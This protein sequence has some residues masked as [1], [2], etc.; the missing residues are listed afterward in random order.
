METKLIK[1]AC[2]CRVSTKSEEQEQ[3]FEAQQA[4]FKEKLS[5]KNGYDLVEIYA[6]RGLSGTDF[7]KREQFNKMLEDCG[8]IKKEVKARETE[9]RKK[10]ISIDYVADAGITPRFN[11][12]YVKDSSRF[13]RNTEVSRIITRLR[14]KGVFVYFEDLNK[15][16]ENPNEK[17]LIDFMF[18]MSEQESIS[19]STKVRFGNVQSAKEGIVRSMRLYGYQYNKEENSLRIIPEE[20]ETVKLIFDLRLEGYGGRAIVTELN[21]RG[22]KNRKGNGWRANTINSMLQNLVYCGKVVRNKW[23]S[24][25]MYGKDIVTLNKRDKWI[26]EDSEKVD[27][28]INEETFEKVQEMIE[29]N[30]QKVGRVQGQYHGRSEFAEKIKCEK[31]GKYYVRNVDRGRIFYNCSTKKQHGTK[32][33]NGRNIQEREIEELIKPYLVLGEY[34]NIT[35]KYIGM[36]IEREE[37]KKA[38]LYMS[39]NI[40]EVN[41]INAEIAEYKKKLAKLTEAFLDDDSEGVNDIFSSKK[42]EL[43]EKIKALEINRNKLSTTDEEK[44]EMF[45]R[46]DIFINYLKEQY[47]KC[48]EEVTRE[49]FINKYLYKIRVSEDGKLNLITY[50]QYGYEK[51]IE[52]MN[53]NII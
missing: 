24:S 17:M 13:A 15:S 20:A 29:G 39:T 9:I 50:A 34:K 25:R 23:Y 32:N 19:R 38:T 12:I 14:D 10:Y 18:S 21:Q 37:E 43:S 46:M 35:K 7:S 11:L 31:C 1:V 3:S 22:I 6:D 49:E 53:K 8:I 2:Y 45:Q 4:Y 41:Q 36:M 5:K 40:E 26:V 42:K 16:T 52:E 48:P 28:I 47:D 44:K 51:I 30:R 27:Q 33:C